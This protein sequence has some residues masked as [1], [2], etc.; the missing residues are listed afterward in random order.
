V[1]LDDSDGVVYVEVVAP[2]VV[3]SNVPP[4]AADHHRKFPD[5]ALVATRFTVPAPQRPTFGAVGAAGAVPVL[6]VATTAVR[7]LVHVPSLK[8]T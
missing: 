5:V 4:V 1:V 6:T 8:S 3:K 7:A 2:V